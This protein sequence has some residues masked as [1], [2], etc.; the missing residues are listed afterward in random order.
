MTT[1]DH[2][3]PE[4]IGS[5]RVSAAV[6]ADRLQDAQRTPVSSRDYEVVR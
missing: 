6:M 3:T 2:R 5:C 1:I 4:R